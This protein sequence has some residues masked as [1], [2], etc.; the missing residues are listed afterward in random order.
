MLNW[1]LELAGM[2]TEAAISDV[3]MKCNEIGVNLPENPWQA[4]REV[5]AALQITRHHAFGYL[6]TLKALE[7]L[8]TDFGQREG[9]EEAAPGARSPHLLRRQKRTLI[10]DFSKGKRRELASEKDKIV[11]ISGDDLAPILVMSPVA[12][13]KK[14]YTRKSRIQLEVESTAAL[15]FE[16]QALVDQLVQLGEFEMRQG[17]SQRGM[18]RMRAAKAICS[19]DVV[20]T[21]GAQAKQLDNVGTA[22][23]IK[24]DQL[25]NKGF[26]AAIS[27]YN[28]DGESLPVAP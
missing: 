21:S 12:S 17:H 6:Q 3:L 24:I 8:K 23:A 2:K 16:N 1:V 19:T 10:Q 22:V 28:G 26:T 13:S 27:E 14:K 20:I 9:D 11:R 18:S 15:R 5:I 4:L 7:K 25:L